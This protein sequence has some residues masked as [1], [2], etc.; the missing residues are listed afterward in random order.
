MRLH[1][2]CFNVNTTQPNDAEWHMDRGTHILQSKE[3]DSREGGRQ[4]LLQ[5]LKEADPPNKQAEL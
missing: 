4:A 2:A 1:D 3:G 5:L